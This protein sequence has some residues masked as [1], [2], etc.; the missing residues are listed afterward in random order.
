VLLECLSDVDL[1]QD[2]ENPT[3]QSLLDMDL[4]TSKE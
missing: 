2:L 3:V 1:P 4:G